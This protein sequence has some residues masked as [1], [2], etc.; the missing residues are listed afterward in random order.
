[1]TGQHLLAHRVAEVVG[2]D[3]RGSDTEVGEQ[4]FVHVRVIV[5]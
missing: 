4:R 2:E 3:V 1:M 5:H